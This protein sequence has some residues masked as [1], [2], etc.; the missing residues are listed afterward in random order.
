M[1]SVQNI[2]AM[3]LF[4]NTLQRRVCTIAFS[5]FFWT[6]FTSTKRHSSRIRCN[7]SS[8]TNTRTCMISITQWLFERLSTHANKIF[9]SRFNMKRIRFVLRRMRSVHIMKMTSLLVKI[10]KWW[11]LKLKSQKFQKQ[12][13]RLSRFFYCI[14]GNH[15]RN[16][17]YIKRWAE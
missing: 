5:C 13:F 11:Q 14:D 1:N 4:D 6:V 15:H 2:H 7:K 17:N 8:R 9:F 3:K 12:N 10:T 16:T